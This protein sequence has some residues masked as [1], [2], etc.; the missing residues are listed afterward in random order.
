MLLP[1]PRSPL[2]ES[3]DVFFSGLVQLYADLL[4]HFLRVLLRVLGGGGKAGLRD[5]RPRRG[6]G[7]P[8]QP[9]TS[10]KPSTRRR[11]YIFNRYT[12]GSLKIVNLHIL[13]RFFQEKV[14]MIL[15]FFGQFTLRQSIFFYSKIM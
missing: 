11:K 6:E 3:V 2:I 15:T 7:G 14:Y 4:L 9:R 10:A 8:Q 13:L 1:G 12:Q 5:L